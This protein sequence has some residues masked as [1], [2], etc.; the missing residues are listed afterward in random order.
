MKTINPSAYLDKFHPGVK[1][2]VQSIHK[3]INGALSLADPSAK[4]PTGFG[5]NTGVYT[6]FNQGNTNGTHIRIAANGVTGTGA[7]YNWAGIGV[8]VLIFHKLGRQP[9]GFAVVDADKDVRIYRTAAPDTNQITLAPTDNT[10]S[11][12]LHIY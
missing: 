10:A 5:I 9:I 11:V 6:Q 1:E 12:T 7:A 8:G 3:A 2:W 4:V